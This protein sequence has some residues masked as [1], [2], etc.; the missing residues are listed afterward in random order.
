[1]LGVVRMCTCVAVSRHEKTIKNRPWAATANP[2]TQQLCCYW[3]DFV[4]NKNEEC[5][6]SRATLEC[7]KQN[8]KMFAVV[9]VQ[10]EYGKFLELL[11]VRLGISL[12]QHMNHDFHVN[13]ASQQPVLEVESA[14]MLHG[15]VT[16]TDSTADDQLQEQAGGRR[17]RGNAADA[18][19]TIPADLLAKMH[20][21]ST[22]DRE[23]FEYAQELFWEQARESLGVSRPNTTDSDG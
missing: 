17:R 18:M 9:G 20:E 19:A 13:V 14:I 21:A 5:P 2:T 8:L 1:V 23:L 6:P 4:G 16:A 3:D 10:E 12:V 11:H 7:A 22:L 15:N